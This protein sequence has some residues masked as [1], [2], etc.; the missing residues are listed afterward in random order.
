MALC[1]VPS[2]VFASWGSTPTF[3]STLS[4]EQNQPKVRATADG[5]AYVSWFDNSTGGFDVR[6]QRLDANGD[7]MWAANGLLIAD[8]GFSSTVDYD[9]SVARNGDALI[10]FNDDRSGS[11]RITVQRV[12]P[13]GSQL[14][15][16]GLTVSTLAGVGAGTGNNP[17]VCELSDGT[18]AVGWTGSSNF[19]VVRVNALGVSVGTPLVVNETGRAMTLSD[20]EAGENGNV[21]AF[22]VRN[23]TTSF[24]S[25]KWLYAQKYSPTN[26]G[27]WT[28]TATGTW[29]NGTPVVVYSMEGVSGYT[30]PQFGSIQNGYFPTILPDGIGG[31]VTAWYENAGPRNAYIQHI[32][33]TGQRLFGPNGTAV[34]GS[35]PIRIKLSAA[36]AFDPWHKEYYVAFEESDVAPQGNYNVLAQRFSPTGARLWGNGVV[37]QA[38]NGNQKSFTQAQ[39][40]GDG[41]FVAGFDSR[42]SLAGVVYQ[43]AVSGDGAEDYGVSSQLLA[44][45]GSTGKSRLTSAL[46]ASGDSL[47][48]WADG[49]SGNQDIAAT[50]MGQDGRIGNGATRV[51]GTIAA[52]DYVGFLPDVNWKLTIQTSE[53]TQTFL[54]RTDANGNWA[55]DT[56]IVGS[57]SITI[58]GSHWLKERFENLTIG[59]SP[60]A[61]TMRNGDV[62]DSGEVDLTDIDLV[63]GAYLS[64]IG[65]ASYDRS[66]D[67]DGSAEVDLTDI[68]VA[69]ANYLEA[70]E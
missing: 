41:V 8:R 37:V 57:G 29:T 9:L 3:L 24:L 27:L 20:L 47:L 68:D 45:D 52:P 63:V 7:E 70:D 35:T 56:D 61:A 53:D 22:W 42:P 15:G 46:A 32:S 4:G 43:S 38:V 64:A 19:T 13:A 28:G 44:Y 36:V 60:I 12:N 23:F 59:A 31:F 1:L 58:D 34:S 26:Q 11:N 39:L 21:I 25:S 5:G 10:T 6:L 50:R 16:S 30:S 54:I 33:A 17:K 49:P 51:T 65:S 2:L 66:V 18:I 48:V 14:F 40:K 62:N 67:L 55:V 69:I